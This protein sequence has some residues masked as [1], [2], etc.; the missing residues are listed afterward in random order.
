MSGETLYLNGDYHMMDWLVMMGVHSGVAVMSRPS[1]CAP[2]LIVAVLCFA[3]RAQ[4]IELNGL[5]SS[6]PALCDKIFVKKGK[7]VA[8]SP[9]S[10][11]YGSGFIIDGNRIRGKIARCTIKS[12]KEEGDTVL[13]AAT[14]ST[15]IA[16]QELEF[17]LK[18]VDDNTVARIFPGS[19]AMR[20]NFHRCPQ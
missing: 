4:A 18:T 12:R 19:S 16:A 17:S 2:A 11:L 9:L 7:Q 14:C 1:L 8:F 13:L 20:V 15:T 6:D 5:W 10:D 3:P